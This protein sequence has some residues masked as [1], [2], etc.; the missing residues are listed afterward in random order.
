MTS[1]ASIRYARA[2]LELA[3]EK[4]SAKK[5]Y[6]D[7]QQIKDT[8]ALNGELSGVLMGAVIAS[9][10][11]R[12]VLR[13]VFK[14]ASA[15]TMN[16]FDVLI[17]NKRVEILDDIAAK[18]IQLY[19]KLNNSQVATV[20]TAVP[21]TKDMEKKIVAK[22]KEL[23]GHEAS[24]KNTIDESILGGFVLRVGDLQYNA[25]I[26]GKLSALKRELTTDAYVSKL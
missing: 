21:L 26:A 6:V 15:E 25:S 16:L 10:I 23:T 8:L 13:S 2:L 20:T 12:N 4:G 9:D 1:R 7:M 19:D 11:K 24:I 22:V 5:V 14:N 17:E 3:Q 18:Y